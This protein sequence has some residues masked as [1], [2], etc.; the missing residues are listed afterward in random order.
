MNH[1]FAFSSAK[2]MVPIKDSHLVTKTRSGMMLPRKAAIKKRLAIFGVVLLVL[3]LAGY[4]FLN[5]IPEEL[6]LSR[7]MQGKPGSALEIAATKACTR[8]ILESV[9]DAKFSS[10]MEGSIV[11]RADGEWKVKRA[12]V[13]QNLF[14]SEI[15][16]IFVCTMKRDQKG[17]WELVELSKVR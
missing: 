6:Q 14:G 7:S 3:S 11:K 1:L 5:Q 12:I 17:R 15:I 10:F 13:K 16:G 8:Y 9:P 4:F 2:E